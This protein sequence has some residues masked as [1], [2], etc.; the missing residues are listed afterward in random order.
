ML[1]KKLGI[2]L[3]LWVI[4]ALALLGMFFMFAVSANL[5]K[6]IIYAPS[7]LWLH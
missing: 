1:L 4:T 3:R 2:R 6:P 5:L 7:V